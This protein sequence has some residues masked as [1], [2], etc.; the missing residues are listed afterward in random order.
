MKVYEFLEKNADV[1]RE[2]AL[3]GVNVQDLRNLPIFKDMQRLRNDGLKM[4]YCVDYVVQ[5]YTIS[6]TTAYRI[7]KEMLHEIRI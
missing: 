4:E 3:A 7:A 2:C 6:R 5:K 1:L